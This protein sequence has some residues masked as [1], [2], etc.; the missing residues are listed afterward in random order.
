MNHIAL[1]KNRI[2]K[3]AW[4]SKTAIPELLGELPDGDPQAELWMGAHRSA[5]SEVNI[6]DRWVPLNRLIET[7]SESLLGKRTAERYKKQLPFLFK[8]LAAA[9]PLSIQAHPDA[10]QAQ[11][12]FEKETTDGIPLSSHKRNYKD[13]NHKPECICAITPFWA[14]NGFRTIPEILSHIERL[15]PKS[16]AQETGDLRKEQSSKSLKLFFKK[17]LTKTKND[18]TLIINEALS[19]LKQQE[20][21]DSVSN[22]II[23]LHEAYPMDIGAMA[24]AFLN[25]VCIHPG[26]AMYLSAGRLHAYLEGVGMELMA[27]SDNVLRGGLTP[28]HVDVPELL[29][30]L[31][32]EETIPEI[33]KPE[34]VSEGVRRYLTPAEEFVLSEIVVDGRIRF[35]NRSEG[36]IEILFCLEGNAKAASGNVEVDLPGGASMIVPAATEAYT[37]EGKAMFYRASV[38]F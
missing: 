22:W 5:P 34:T 25:L 21:S 32:F 31:Q 19:H 18:V 27:N 35:Q 6:G 8:V 11:R 38:G 29:K 16:L 7:D 12:G 37:I 9:M 10:I 2:Q 1:L 13:G 14:L 26:E 24:P 20:S 17:L 23:R 4:G 15:C 33:L 28:K 36:G 3:Y 30:V